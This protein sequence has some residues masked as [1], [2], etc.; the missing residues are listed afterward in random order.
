LTSSFPCEFS[1]KLRGLEEIARWKATELRTFLLYVGP[2]VLK[3]NVSNECF[4]HFMSLKIAMII[5]LSLHFSSYLQYAQHLLK[6]FVEMFEK[7]YG[8][9]LISHNIHGFLHIADNYKIYGPLD[10]CSAYPFENYMKKLKSI[11]RKPDKLLEQ[12]IHRYHESSEIIDSDSHNIIDENAYKLL[13]PHNKGPLIDGTISN[14]QYKTTSFVKFILKTKND[15][16]LYF[17]TKQKCGKTS[18]VVFQ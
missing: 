10:Q 18:N 16:D 13:G 11:L 15:A 9:Y 1:R 17:Y 14:P 7:M 5:L 8:S 6:Y 2:L 3:N 4:K 12:V